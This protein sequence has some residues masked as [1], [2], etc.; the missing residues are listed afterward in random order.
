MIH[1]IC[2][3]FIFKN[4]LNILTYKKP[5]AHIKLQS[6]NNFFIQ[7][8]NSLNYYKMYNEFFDHF[9]FKSSLLLSLQINKQK[10]ILYFKRLILITQFNK[11]QNIAQMKILTCFSKEEKKQAKIRFIQTD[12][13]EKIQHGFEK[14]NHEL[15]E[16]LKHCYNLEQMQYFSSLLQH[17][18]IQKTNQTLSFCLKINGLFE[19]SILVSKTELKDQVKEDSLK[20]QSLTEKFKKM[21]QMIKKDFKLHSLFL[22]NILKKNDLISAMKEKQI[23]TFVDLTVKE[24]TIM[25]DLIILTK[26]TKLSKYIIV[27]TAFSM[28]QY[29]DML[30]VFKKCQNQLHKYKLKVLMSKFWIH[31]AILK[32]TEFLTQKMFYLIDTFVFNPSLLHQTDWSLPE[33]LKNFSEKN[34]E[35]RKNM[36]LKIYLKKLKQVFYLSKLKQFNNDQSLQNVQYDKLKNKSDLIFE[37]IQKY[38]RQITRIEK[39]RKW[40]LINYSK[41][42]N[43]LKQINEKLNQTINDKFCNDLV[44]AKNGSNVNL[45]D[46]LDFNSKAINQ[47][48]STDNLITE[49]NVPMLSNIFDS[50]KLWMKI[51]NLKTL[52]LNLKQAS[53]TSFI[54]NT[55]LPLPLLPEAQKQG[56]TDKEKTYKTKAE[57]TQKESLAYFLNYKTVFNCYK[58]AFVLEQKQ[59]KW[60]LKMFTMLKKMKSLLKNQ[61]LNLNQKNRTV[62]TKQIVLQVQGFIKISSFLMDSLVNLQNSYNKNN[63]D[64]Q[65]LRDLIDLLN[66]IDQNKKF[67]LQSQ[68]Y[69]LKRKILQNWFILSSEATLNHLTIKTKTFKIKTLLHMFDLAWQ[70]VFYLSTKHP[71]SRQNMS[72]KM[73]T[74]S[75]EKTNQ[76]L[77]H[78]NKNIYFCAFKQ[79]NM[80][81]IKKVICNMELTLQNIIHSNF[82]KKTN[83]LSHHYDLA[84]KNRIHHLTNKTKQVAQPFNNEDKKLNSFFEDKTNPM[85]LNFLKLQQYQKNKVGI[86]IQNWIKMFAKWTVLGFKKRN[87]SSYQTSMHNQRLKKQLLKK[88]ILRSNNVQAFFGV[89]V[90]KDFD[91]VTQKQMNFLNFTLQARFKKQKIQRLINLCHFSLNHLSFKPNVS[92]V[93][94]QQKIYLVS[95]LSI[96]Y[97]CKQNNIINQKKYETIKSKIQKMFGYLQILAHMSILKQKD[98]IELNDYKNLTQKIYQ[99]IRQKMRQ[100]KIRAKLTMY[101]QLIQN[102]KQKIKT[103]KKEANGKKVKI[104]TNKKNGSISTQFMM[105][106]TLTKKPKSFLTFSSLK[107]EGRW[108][109]IL[110]KQLK[111]QKLI[112]DQQSLELEKQ[113]QNQIQKKIQQMA[114]LMNQISGLN[115]TTF[116]KSINLIKQKNRPQMLMTKSLLMKNLFLSLRTKS[117]FGMLEPLNKQKQINPVVLKSFSKKMSVFTKNRIQTKKPSKVSKLNLKMIV[118]QT[119]PKFSKSVENKTKLNS[120]EKLQNSKH[121]SNFVALFLLNICIKRLNHL[122]QIKTN[123]KL[124]TKFFTDLQTS[125]STKTEFNLFRRMEQLLSFLFY[126]KQNL[127][128]VLKSKLNTL[129]S[130]SEFLIFS[131]NTNSINQRFFSYFQNQNEKTKLSLK[132]TSSSLKQLKKPSKLLVSKFNMVNKNQLTKMTSGFLTSYSKQLISLLNSG[133]SLLN[134]NR[135]QKLKQKG[136]I[137]SKN[138]VYLGL[139]M[140]LTFKRI[141]NLFEFYKKKKITLIQT[142]QIQQ[143]LLKSYIKTE[144]R[145]LQYNFRKTKIQG[146][147]QQKVKK[148][149]EQKINLYAKAA[150]SLKNN[151]N[152]QKSFVISPLLK[153]FINQLPPKRNQRIASMLRKLRQKLS[154]DENVIKK[155][156]PQ[157][158]EFLEKRFGP[159]LPIPPHLILKRWKIKAPKNSLKQKEKKK[160]LVLPIGIVQQM[161]ARKTVGIAILERLIVE[162]YSRR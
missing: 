138:H 40:K 68:T 75:L 39:Q 120:I 20:L 84:I 106:S 1:N 94:T 99:K 102:V 116:K 133:Q 38:R 112:N 2:P 77:Q 70:N 47:V 83:H 9:N 132:K 35:Q 31:P 107:K 8:N 22:L 57:N 73:S 60:K 122:I 146:R 27:L 28:R 53:L 135:L 58:Q 91:F 24:S 14:Q 86:K 34:T 110:L 118:K 45:Q 150:D 79:S 114:T 152:K 61:F 80:N 54:E 25:K 93:V 52:I 44:D 63:I 161:A 56:H 95:L 155:I 7:L 89:S 158:I 29:L 149:S 145:M 23:K 139:Q 42:E 115:K 101:S 76:L 134:I 33:K 16:Q 15:L 65:S 74:F 148:M 87:S 136:L 159:S 37:M 96:L 64:K 81:Q 108:A 82:H 55:I 5:F 160:F 97:Q 10:K 72:L 11:N 105:S 143:S 4:S 121:F 111:K 13:L 12:F 85:L 98:L 162:Y 157:L 30:D 41:Y 50:T 19:Q 59:K 104:E 71:I 141:E 46:K 125:N 123:Q 109:L 129:L 119:Q 49:S 43:V 17:L 153:N 131:K 140:K 130:S 90:F 156:Q 127:P 92:V 36:H 48:Q 21:K 117:Y 154:F 18:L 142:Q 51:E 137:H 88:L 128:F 32:K 124:S 151:M 6:L 3:V 67:L 26:K 66:K 100:A 113:I 69:K 78:F 103:T 144:L 147:K 126:Q 62:S